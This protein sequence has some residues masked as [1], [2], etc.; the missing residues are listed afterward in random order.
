M[1]NFNTSIYLGLGF[2]LTAQ[3]ARCGG[4]D[5]P[6]LTSKTPQLPQGAYQIAA[7]GDTVGTGEAVYGK[8]KGYVF[9]SDDGRAPASV[10]YVTSLQGAR[11]VPYESSGKTLTY[12]LQ[13]PI[14]LEPLNSLNV[15]GNYSSWFAGQTVA[16]KIDSEGM[17][18][19]GASACKISGNVNFQNDYGNA[20]PVTLNISGCQKLQ[21]GSYTGLMYMSEKL[22]PASFKIIAENGTQIIDLLAFR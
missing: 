13:K 21:S 8:E 4:D 14:F 20:L 9:L 5:S 19:A 2:F 17:M 1:K 6:V 7:E 11:R 3:L 12:V 10:L 22:K 18:V 16:F 15:K